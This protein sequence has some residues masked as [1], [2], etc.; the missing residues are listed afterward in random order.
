MSTDAELRDAAVAELKLTTI[1]FKN[2]KWTTPPAGSHWANAL[3][4]LAQI[5]ATAPPPPTSDTQTFA[6]WATQPKPAFTAQRTIVCS[7]VSA[8]NA[9]YQALTPGDLLDVRGVVFP[10]ET[11]FSKALAAP[12]EI[13]FDS[14][15]RFTGTAKG[16][17]LPAVWL[18]GQRNV[19]MY[20]G[21]IVNPGGVGILC[22]TGDHH[23]WDFKA[24]DCAIHGGACYAVGGPVAA[25]LRGEVWNCGLDLTLDPHAEKGTGLH[26]WYWAD[27]K[28][29]PV[30]GRIVLDVHDQPTGAAL[31]LGPGARDVEVAIRANR[32]TFPAQ[33][34]IAGNAFQ[35]WTYNGVS[36]TNIRVRYLEAHDC[37]GRAVDGGNGSFVNVT[38][39]YGRASN[40]CLN[41]KLDKTVWKPS[42]G[43]SYLDCVA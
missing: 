2:N 20:G 15:C 16:S 32:L 18:N 4:L 22:Y 10:G 29:D 33:S 12:A 21:D 9:A 11:V 1:G 41:P 7:T 36:P 39:E 35:P 34:Q 3:G 8:F 27:S 38:V 30:S 14:G 43:I 24:H 13:R 37:Q 5:G 31:Q 42:A 23:W 6:Y 28:P 40:M 17:Q 26:A 25:D 19:R